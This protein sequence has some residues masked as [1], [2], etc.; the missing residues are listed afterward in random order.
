LACTVA[1]GIPLSQYYRR[2]G[3]NLAVPG[4]THAFVNAVRNALGLQ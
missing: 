3:Q 2:G 4:I 1:I